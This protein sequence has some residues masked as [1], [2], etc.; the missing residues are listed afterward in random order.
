MRI[1]KGAS[2]GVFLAGRGI[3]GYM[4]IADRTKIVGVVPADPSESI[5]VMIDRQHTDEAKAFLGGYA[6]VAVAA[7]YSFVQLWNGSAVKDLYVTKIICS[8]AVTGVYIYQLRRS[9]VGLTH[10]AGGQLKSA[11]GTGHG[12][13]RSGTSAVMPGTLNMTW[14]QDYRS[15]PLI[16][17]FPEPIK[18]TQNNGLIYTSAT[19]NLLIVASFEWLEFP[20]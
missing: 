8:P 16:I 2:L 7:Q 3:G 19:L 15:G 4:G 10:R 14:L 6:Q 20:V 18:L 5:P 17:P 13:I 11:I 9:T 1:R 12:G